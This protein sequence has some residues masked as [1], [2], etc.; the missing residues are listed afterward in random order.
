MSKHKPD[1]D[2]L[3]KAGKE[4]N[5]QVMVAMLKGNAHEE[6]VNAYFNLKDA[7]HGNP[8]WGKTCKK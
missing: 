7:I 2:A 4:L 6:L 1:I 3:V 5:K 8:N